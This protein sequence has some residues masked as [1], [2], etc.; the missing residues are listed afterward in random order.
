M[1]KL[2]IDTFEEEKDAH[3]TVTLSYSYSDISIELERENC[4]KIEVTLSEQEFASFIINVVSSLDKGK[5]KKDINHWR[6]VTEP[7]NSTVLIQKF[8]HNNCLTEHVEMTEEAAIKK[9]TEI[10]NGRKIIHQEIF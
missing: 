2:V 10:K 8:V 7:S 6:I 1:F 3:D 4:E 5:S 9:L